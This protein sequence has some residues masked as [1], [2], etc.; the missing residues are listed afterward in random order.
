MIEVS[1]ETSIFL[2]YFGK[3]VSLGSKWF[4]APVHGFRKQPEPADQNE[5]NI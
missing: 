3:Y 4:E 1:P 2:V 5:P